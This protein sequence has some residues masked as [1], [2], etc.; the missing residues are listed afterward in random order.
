MAWVTPAAPAGQGQ[1]NSPEAR[2]INVGAIQLDANLSGKL[3]TV[4]PYRQFDVMITPEAG[5]AIGQ[6]AN[7]PVLTASIR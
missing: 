1:A 3:Q 6:P 4:T 7:P 2:R 5:P